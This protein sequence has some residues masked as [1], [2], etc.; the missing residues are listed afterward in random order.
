MRSYPTIA[1][2]IL[3]ATLAAGCATVVIPHPT[4]LNAEKSGVALTSL[5]HGRGLFVA[6]CGNCHETPS[7]TSRSPEQWAV[8]LPEMTKDS[9]LNPE[10]AGQ[11]LAFLKAVSAN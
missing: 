11:L 5:E 3:G 2:F 6:R 9:N 8:I 4:A 10:E 7:P 1:G